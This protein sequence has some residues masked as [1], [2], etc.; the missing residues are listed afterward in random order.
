MPGLGRPDAGSPISQYIQPILPAK[1]NRTQ[2][3][4]PPTSGKTYPIKLS[5]YVRYVTS[6]QIDGNRVHERVTSLE[7]YNNCGC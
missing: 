1:G 5:A 6:S 2:R 3:M 4:K 7:L